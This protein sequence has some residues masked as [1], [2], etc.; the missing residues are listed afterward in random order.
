MKME[1][2]R[3][4][5]KANYNIKDSNSKAY[6]E[7]FMHVGKEHCAPDTA[8]VHENIKVRLKEKKLVN[9]IG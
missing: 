2:L 6:Q 5:Y 9:I 4:E 8:K 3:H 1:F 7:V